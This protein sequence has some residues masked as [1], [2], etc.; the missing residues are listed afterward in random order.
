MHL[1]SL[2]YTFAAAL[3]LISQH[4]SEGVYLKT[5]ADG[6]LF[7]LSRLK[8][9]SRVR[10]VCVRELLY[11]DDSALVSSRE[12]AL[13][14]MLQ[15]FDA[16]ARSLGLTINRAK[17]KNRFQ[18]PR[19]QPYCT[20]NIK[21]KEEVLKDVQH[22]TYLGST[23]CN[24]TSLGQEVEKRISSATAAFG[25]LRTR[26]WSWP[27]IR[28]E[29]KCKVYQTAV[30][31]CLLYSSETYTLYR[32]H[33]RQLQ[34]VQCSHLRSI[35]K[36]KWQD[37]DSNVDLFRRANMPI[38]EAMLVKKQLPWAGHLVWTGDHRHPKARLLW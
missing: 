21:L 18:P 7:N 17:T 33:I 2:V 35:M 4:Q 38:L 12:D 20:P 6:K 11:A 16:V 29:T 5:R 36:V 15:K 32:K 25:R 10:S 28:P 8:A 9:A 3:D 19:G 13:Q 37:H 24:D 14:Q 22:F 34:R 1:H 27:G 23:V 26:V 30:L 31:L